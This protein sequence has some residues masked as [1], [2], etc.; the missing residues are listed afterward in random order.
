MTNNTEQTS[1]KLAEILTKMNMSELPAMSNNVQELIS[2]VHSSRSAAYDL[3]RVILK[4]YSLTNKVLQV[5][6]SA[7]YSL[8]QS[9]SS[10]SK[11]VTILGFDSVR[12]LATAIALFDDFIKSG[13]DKEGISKLMTRSFLSALQCRDLV[14]A[15]NLNVK[16]E[17]AFICGLL[18]N[19]GKII[20]F[21][22]MPEIYKEIEKKVAAGMT[23]ETAARSLLED[24]TFSDLGK[25]IAKFWNM[26]NKVV[27]S[28]NRNPTQPK[29]NDDTEG[30]LQNLSDFSNRFVDQICNGEDP[31]DLVK[32]YTGI[33]SID[34]D[35]AV[36]MLNDCVEASQDIS[37]SIRY[38]LSKLKIHSKLE[39]AAKNELAPPKKPVIILE[40][41]AESKKKKEQ[42]NIVELDD[43][44]SSDK[45]INEFIKDITGT[46]M[47][48]FQINEFY[49]NLLE[50]IYRG[51]GFDR[52]ILG[53]L[54][55]QATQIVLVGRFGLGDIKK[56]EIA[57]FE[58]PLAN[59][60]QA[61]PKAMKQCKDVAIEPNAPAAFPDN[62]QY[63]VK[64]RTT[65]LFPIS[66]NNRAIGLLYM[67]RKKGRPKLDKNQIKAV[68]LFRDFA[69][70]A[71]K[72][73]SKKS[74]KKK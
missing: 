51:V 56:E 26:S 37:D 69:G 60:D 17:E 9:V 42:P 29:N 33:V 67:D 25:E 24:L 39:K 15:K 23:E 65:Y 47:G 27:V 57:S 35:E 2:L 63:L 40:Q 62:L 12:D 7:Y 11:A 3:S 74:S 28:M 36:A 41:D 14:N 68:R 10:I 58:Q 66:I 49:A 52:V 20:T 1:G 53:I 16:P 31:S 43:L 48:S 34:M 30:L 45:T 71:I 6:N 61:I 55:V 54:S 4:D 44:P 70:M 18:H 32:K 50:A 38:G 72:K 19:L 13:V 22:Y 5:V 21:L 73:S 46:L 59:V 64:N 8:G